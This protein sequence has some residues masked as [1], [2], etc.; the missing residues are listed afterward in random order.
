VEMSMVFHR[1]GPKCQ[2][3]CRDAARGK[4]HFEW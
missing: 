4:H 2:R 3:Y 1:Y